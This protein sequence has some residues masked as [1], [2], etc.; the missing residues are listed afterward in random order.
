MA[1]TDNRVY[2]ISQILKATT[3]LTRETRGSL[4]ARLTNPSGGGGFRIR[5]H[6][7]M[8]VRQDFT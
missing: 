3:K 6:T 8:V 7:Y 5:R 4:P 2:S 1:L